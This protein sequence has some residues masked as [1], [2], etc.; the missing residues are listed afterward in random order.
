MNRLGIV[1]GRLSPPIDNHIQAFPLDNWKKEFQ[2]YNELGISIIDWLF[3][4]ETVKEN[5]LCSDSGIENIKYLCKKHNISI[6]GVLS[7]YFMR[8]KLFD[9]EKKD[10]DESIKMLFFL[11]DQ[12]KK[13]RISKIILPFVDEAKIK[14][15]NDEKEIIEN[16][17]KPIKY[18]NDNG[19]IILIEGALN[20]EEFK[21]FILSFKPLRVKIN[22]DM[23]NSTSL[24]YDP[25]YEINILGKFFGSVHIKDR[26]QG[27]GSVPLGTG[28]VDFNTVFSELKIIDYSDNFILEAARQDLKDSKFKSN[29]IET[30][31]KYINF[32][33]PFMEGF[34]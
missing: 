28:D 32:V 22:Y 13:A 18:A 25:K 23:G 16:L 9:E 29:R 27:G 12:C 1:Q 19:I 3:K 5:P 6:N 26:K 7:D 4:Y 10:V 20:P 31:K 21:D 24:G 30:I 2:I 8:K 11:I 15:K 33:K 34:K 14:N 17:K